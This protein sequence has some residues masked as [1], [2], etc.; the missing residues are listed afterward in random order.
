MLTL[1]QRLQEVLDAGH[2]RADL[3][4]FAGVTE[5]A[6]TH[7]MNGHTRSLKGVTTARLEQ[8][9]GFRAAWIASGRGPKLVAP[10][11]QGDMLLPKEVEL[12]NALRLLTDDEREAHTKAI[13]EAARHNQ[14]VV[15]QH[16]KRLA[17]ADPSRVAKKR[18][19]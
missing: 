2:T 12:I 10:S 17:E 4:R 11:E 6:V 1:A 7:W 5:A 8:R 14:A 13:I 16:L 19:L 3:A 9:T 18:T 15:E